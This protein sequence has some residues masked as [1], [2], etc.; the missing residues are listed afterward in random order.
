M[1]KVLI[2]TDESE[3]IKGIAASIASALTGFSVAICEAG[4]FTG[5][6]L[7]PVDLFF[8]GCETP[9]PASFEYLDRF[10]KHINLAG[11][12]CGIF[13]T[14]DS[15]IKYLNDLLEQSEVNAGKPLLLETQEKNILDN[16]LKDIIG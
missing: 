9:K 15:A 5:N 3:P 11:R 1:K 2:L 14:N 6:D 12:K 4:N 7:F 10:F 8:I 16:W 13:S